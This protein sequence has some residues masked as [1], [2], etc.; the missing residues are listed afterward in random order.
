M[1]KICN[2]NRINVNIYDKK[3]GFKDSDLI[4]STKNSKFAILLENETNLSLTIKKMAVADIPV[5]VWGTNRPSDWNDE[6]GCYVTE[7]NLLENLFEN[8][9]NNYD[10]YT[11]RKYIID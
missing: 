6:L 1:I 5:F 8:F 2:K 9:I 11:P 10:D 7:Q 3:K 4:A